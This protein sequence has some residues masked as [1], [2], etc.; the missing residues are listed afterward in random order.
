MM[1]ENHEARCLFLAVLALRNAEAQNRYLD[2]AC[3]DKPELRQR[4]ERLLREH[5]HAGS[6]LEEPAFPSPRLT[7]IPADPVTEKPGDQLGRY[8]LLQQIGEGG[9]G[10]V[11]M[12]EQQEP[13]R[14]RVA[15]KVIKLGMDTKQVIARFEAERQALALMDHPNIAKVLDAGTTDSGRP[16]FVMELV[17]GTKITEH[18]D[19]HCL[20]TRERLNLFV[21]VCHA[22]QHAHQ[23]GVIHR[24]IKPSNILVTINDGVPV[25]KVIDFGI[26]KAIDHQLTD[27][28]VFTAFEQFIGTPAYMSPEQ[29]VMT[30]LDIDTRSDIYALGVLLYELLTGYTPFEQ[31]E[32]IAA[33]LDEMRRIIREQEP[34][35]PSTRLR[36]K[37]QAQSLGSGDSA[38]PTLHSAIDTDLDWIVMK[39]LEKNRARRYETANGLADDVTRHLQDE[40]VVARPPSMVDRVQKTFRRHRLIFTTTV[41]LGFAFLLAVLV[42][43]WQ[44]ILA[45]VLGAFVGIWQAVRATRAARRE[46]ASRVQS[47]QA[48]RLAESQ[49]ERAEKEAQR[50]QASELAAREQAYAADMNLAQQALAMNNLSLANSLLATYR[51]RPGERDLRGW[52][53]R[54]LWGQCRS[55]DALSELCRYPTGLAHLEYAPDGATLAV[56]GWHG[57]VEIW[58]LADRKKIASLPAEESFLVAFSPGGD[59]LATAAAQGLNIWHAGTTKLAHQLTDLGGVK[60]VRALRFSPGGTWLAAINRPRLNRPG[61]VLVWRVDGWSIACRLSVPL[62]P[63]KPMH[64]LAFS[65]D[66][67][68]LAVGLGD[69]SLCVIDPQN[70]NKN[71]II[72][73]H[74]ETT[75]AV[76]WSPKAA[77]LA[78]GSGLSGGPIRLWDPTSGKPLGALEGHTSYVY[79][80]VFSADGQRLYSTG[81]DQTIRIWDVATRKC[82]GVLRGS[83]DELFGLALSPD[84]TTLASASKN[85]VVTFWSALPPGEER[86]AVLSMTTDALGFAPAF[87]PDSQ[88]IA[89]AKHGLI[90]L[91]SAPTFREIESIPAMGTN[92]G[93]AAWSPDGQVI[94]SGSED[95]QVRLWSCAQRRLLRELSGPKDGV[96]FLSFS[97]DGTRILAG[98]REAGGIRQICWD[99]RTGEPVWSLSDPGPNLGNATAVAI[100]PDGRVV[101]NGDGLGKVTWWDIAARKPLAATATHQFCSGIAFSPDGKQV[102][103]LG[104]NGTFTLWDASS[105]KPLATFR[106]SRQTQSTVTF[107]ADG[108]RLA[109]GGYGSREAVTL[110]DLRTHRELLTLPGEGMGFWFVAFSPD[111]NWLATSN[112]KHQLQLWRAPTWEEIEQN[113]P[114]R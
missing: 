41:A 109:T 75:T 33:G 44:T 105:F 60:T 65:A 25:P 112:Y 38:L 70:G 83:S 3:Q 53:W 108:R 62:G 77:I 80:L 39:C 35:R 59:L 96:G 63:I 2:L 73:A 22:I 10:V 67:N 78:S 28:T 107:S 19:E 4:V 48:A 103:T 45:L 86:P 11:Y 72:A 71:L 54:Y 81:G 46:A 106:G 56:A 57:F 55:S 95:G 15:L 91:C 32:L 79:Q 1:S 37:E 7:S 24:D 50:A 17:R 52:E 88:V 13:I 89:V 93:S 64:A 21:Q 74:P 30:S 66:E 87:S 85:G 14:R 84:G 49:K 76:A 111:G 43:T 114:N 40:P 36:Q 97:A 27:K 101:V 61:E 42:S 58:N 104:G 16:F 23:K 82:L 92:L 102:A 113:D 94:A 98:G 8:K 69:G 26:A 51:P 20:S 110:W 9:C 47:D 31:Q 68:A 6:F 99:V 18:C 100:S 90:S 12:A 29:A 34:V 5:Q